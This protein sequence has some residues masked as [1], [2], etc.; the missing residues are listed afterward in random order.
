MIAMMISFKIVVKP[1]VSNK[2]ISVYHKRW[3]RQTSFHYYNGVRHGQFHKSCLEMLYCWIDLSRDFQ[4]VEQLPWLKM[5]K[6]PPRPTIG[7]CCPCMEHWCLY[8]TLIIWSNFTKIQVRVPRIRLI[9]HGWHGNSCL[10]VFHR[11]FKFPKNYFNNSRPLS[12]SPNGSSAEPLGWRQSGASTHHPAELD[13]SSWDTSASSRC[14]P[15]GGLG[16]KD[17]KSW[18]VLLMYCYKDPQQNRLDGGWWGL[19]GRY[20]WPRTHL[21][22]L[23]GLQVDNRRKGNSIIILYSYY[24]RADALKSKNHLYT[25]HYNTG[26]GSHFVL[27]I[28]PYQGAR[29]WDFCPRDFSR[30][31]A[32]AILSSGRCCRC[33]DLA[34]AVRHKL[35]GIETTNSEWEKSRCAS[36]LSNMWQQKKV[37]WWI[38]SSSGA[39]LRR[40]IIYINYIC[41]YHVYVRSTNI[42]IN[43]ITTRPL[44]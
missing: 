31:R 37:S 32:A 24:T 40:Y 44:L 28:I 20:S 1:M 30:S 22:E 15:G 14:R 13:V 5:L 2:A 4:I 16:I 33:G 19:E 17:W 34:S 23:Q 3:S 12:T 41:A 6:I 7:H 26:Q 18:M 38:F 29:N 35:R 21:L 10:C 39:R 43:I 27:W 11:P 8:H 36:S 42:D 25:I 9:T